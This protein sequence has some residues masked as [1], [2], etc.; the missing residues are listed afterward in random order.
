MHEVAIHEPLRKVLVLFEGGP[1][2]LRVDKKIDE[3]VAKKCGDKEGGKIVPMA[4]EWGQ[5]KIKVTRV[6]STWVDRT[7]RPYRYRFSLTMETGEIFQVSYEEGNPV[8]KLE[9]VLTDG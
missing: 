7:L 8:W 3:K 1:A 4:I 2:H 5:R 9:Y 6:N